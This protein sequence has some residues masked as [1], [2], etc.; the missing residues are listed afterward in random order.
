M[1]TATRQRGATSAIS[2]GDLAEC[3]VHLFESLPLEPC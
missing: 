1:S 3:Q 2:D